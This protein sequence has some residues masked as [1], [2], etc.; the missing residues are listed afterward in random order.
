LGQGV[1]LPHARIVGLDAPIGAFMQMQPAIDYDALDNQPVDLI[2]ALLV[3]DN[4]AVAHDIHLKILAKLAGV[5]SDADNLQ[6]LREAEDGQDL[7]SLIIRQA[8]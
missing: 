6:K 7:F 5:F 3:P 1:A 8:G 4:E 2:C